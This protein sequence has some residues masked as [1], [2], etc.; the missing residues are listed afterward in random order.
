ML[1]GG[2][3]HDGKRVLKSKMKER[4]VEDG[5]QLL[6]HSGIRYCRR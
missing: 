2:I 5:K 3:D 6:W 1:R 4:R